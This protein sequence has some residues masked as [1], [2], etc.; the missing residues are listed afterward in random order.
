LAALVFHI[1]NPH[2]AV[3][4]RYIALAFAPLI[5]LAPV[6]AERMSQLIRQR[7]LRR[8]AQLALLTTAVIV[9]FMSAPVAAKRAP[10]GARDTV[11]FLRTRGALSGITV[12]LVSDERGEGAIVSEVAQRHPVPAATVVRGSKL[13]A[14]DDW[15]GN[16]FRMLYPSARDLLRDLEDLHVDYLVMDYSPT[17]AAVPFWGQADELVE[18]NGGRLEQVYSTTRGRRL[19]TYRLKYRTPGPP[20]PLEVPLTYS[21][22]KVLSR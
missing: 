21:L 19:V 16:R 1:L 4:P 3:S 9:S 2:L 14:S 13:L 15:A 10:I 11:D 12:L 18:N 5:A 22:G 8:P 6:G 20:K 7:S 17:A